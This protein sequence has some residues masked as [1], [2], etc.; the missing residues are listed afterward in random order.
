MSNN[1]NGNKIKYL[2]IHLTKEAQD[3]LNEHFK[4]LLKEIKYENVKLYSSF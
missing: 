4:T 1:I 3:L 2:E